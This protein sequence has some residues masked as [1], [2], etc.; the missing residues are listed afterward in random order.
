MT[1]REDGAAATDR[2]AQARGQ[3]TG[4]ARAGV[5]RRT[6]FGVFLFFSLGYFI[7]YVFRGVNIGFAPFLAQEIGLSASS[8]GLLTGTY[9]LAFA[10][11]QIPA[12]ILIDTYGPRRVNALMMLIAVVGTVVFG[13]AH[14]LAGL[15]LGRMLIGIG[16]SVCLGAAFKALV[17]VFPLSRLPL[18]NGF[19]MAVGGMG[20]V[21]VGTPLNWLLGIVDWRVVSIALAVPTLLVAASVWWGVRID[22][23]TP[24]QRPSLHEQWQGTLS[25]LRDLG[26]WKIA[27][28][29]V[30]TGGAFYA[31]QSL[32]VGA[33]LRDVE[34]YAPA[35]A[36]TL[37]SLLGAAMVLGNIVLGAVANHVKRMGIS[38]Y[39]FGGACMCLYLLVQLLIILPVTL[40]A[41]PLWVAYGVFGSS[42]ILA[43]A[44]VAERFPYAMLGRVSTTLTFSMFLLIFVCQAGLGGIVSLWERLPSGQ[45]PVQ[46]HVTAW[47]VL[48]AAQVA[49]AVWYCW[50]SRR[51]RAAP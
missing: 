31:V 50:P 29:P 35:Y 42:N 4:K 5:D 11:V 9:F 33:Y 20:G 51:P 32:W 21:V 40:P 1:P 12:G 18:V 25:V 46:A 22:D 41:A 16:V 7:S 13:M 39:V 28:L 3:R 26:F 44:V 47:A 19:V 10:A 14:S 27:S 36:A 38:L 49:G 24:A 34:G 37:V 8:L 23:G 17:Q 48:L 43:Y 30:L 45:Y 2:G 15:L 6:T